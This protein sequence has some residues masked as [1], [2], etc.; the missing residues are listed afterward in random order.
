[1]TV[2]EVPVAVSVWGRTDRRRGNDML[3]IA[4]L[5]WQNVKKRTPPDLAPTA[6]S[7]TRTSR[8]GVAVCLTFSHTAGQP[9]SGSGSGVA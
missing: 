2:S 7:T 1:M 9:V 5:R 3:A 6:F 8:P 4:L